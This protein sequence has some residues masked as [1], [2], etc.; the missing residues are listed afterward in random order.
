MQ[1]F[2]S[3]STAIDAV[4][5]AAA[6]ADDSAIANTDIHGTTVRT[7]HTSGLYPAVGL[8]EDAL[9]NAF[10]P[11]AVVRSPWSPNVGNAVASLPDWSGVFGQLVHAIGSRQFLFQE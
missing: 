5:S 4:Y 8:F 1:S 11:R 7:K 10:G 6:Y 9:V 2:R 3:Q